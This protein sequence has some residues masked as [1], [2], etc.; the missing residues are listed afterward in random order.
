MNSNYTE[1]LTNDEK[2]CS[3]LMT[4]VH[5]RQSKSI[6]KMLIKTADSVLTKYGQ[7]KYYDDPKF[8]I[9]IAS[10]KYEEWI[11]TVFCRM[12]SDS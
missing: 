5:E 3:F 11:D 6:H 9:S 1:I 10:W 4:P 12:D 2:T 8:H 7:K